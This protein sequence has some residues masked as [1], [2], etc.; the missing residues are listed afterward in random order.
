M[1]AVSNFTMGNYPGNV[2]LFM[3]S[4]NLSLYLNLN[5]T[6]FKTPLLLE[7][8]IRLYCLFIFAHEEPMIFHVFSLI[9]NGTDMLGHSAISQTD[10]QQ[11]VGKGC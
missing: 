8:F 11:Q 10:K 3:K 1:S 6:T 5:L 4:V 9:V 7:F 2:Y